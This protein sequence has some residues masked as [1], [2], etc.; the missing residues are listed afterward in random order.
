MGRWPLLQ[1]MGKLEVKFWGVRGSVPAPGPQ[2]TV[3]GGNTSCVEVRAGDELLIL[4]MGSGLRA[5]GQELSGTPRRASMLLSHYH[6][7]H[8]QGLPFFGPVYD[9]RF[10]FDI[11]GATRDARGIR[12]LLAGQMSPPYFPVSLETCRAKLTFH[13][14]ADREVL[15]IGEAR[16]TA[17]ELNHPNGALGYRID[18]AGRSLV[19]ATDNEHG[20]RT[21]DTLVELASGADVLIYDAMYT[22]AE[23]S[24]DGKSSRVGWGH[25]TWEA[26]VLTARRAGARTLVLFHHDPGRTD[27]GLEEIL[28]QARKQHPNTRMAREGKTLEL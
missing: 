16:V 20:T 11:Y 7:D 18:Y 10:S 12:E 6:W 23:Y 22:P 26:G 15:A 25:S 13:P 2:T 27:E 9:P 17:R 4:D 8:I 14:V 24:G 5:L 3:Y 21:D 1:N 28:G 19:Y